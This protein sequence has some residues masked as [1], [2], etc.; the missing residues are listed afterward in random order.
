MTTDKR[1]NRNKYIGLAFGLILI[2][3]TTAGYFLRRG[4]KPIIVQTEKVTLRNLTEVVIANGK[5]QPV[6]QVTINPEVSGEIIALAIKEGQSVKVG[7][8]LLKLKPDNYIASRNSS[9]ANYKSAQANVHLAQANLDKSELE[10]KRYKKLFEEKLVS[11][12]E[13]LNAKT[14]WEVQKATH[15][16]SIHGAAQAKA[17]LAR[18]EDDLSKTSITSPLDGTVTKLRSQLGERVVGTAMMAGTEIMTIANLNAIEARVDIGEIDIPLLAIGQI[19]HLEIEAFRDRKFHGRVTDIANASKNAGTGNSSSAS[20][21]TGSTE[22]TK[23]EVKILLEDKDIFRPGMSVTA[24]IETRARSNV[25]TVPIQSVTTRLPKKLILQNKTMEPETDPALTKQKV[26]PE[27]Q[28]DEV[29]FL[30][31][32]SVAKI[33]KV[34]TGI[35]DDFHIEIIEGLKVGQEVVSG[36]YK[37]I[38]RDLEDLKKIQINQNPEGRPKN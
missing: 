38:S 24:E 10:F 2:A 31:E 32:S 21:A 6:I 9:E 37:T 34:K 26:S 18:A 36:G 25:V 1:S 35:R 12:S 13:F 30:V 29:V 15:E 33:A 19:A 3:S 5:I 22:A 7:D 11:D 4:E 28:A 17:A 16:T 23:F 20:A 14:S 8:L 27:K